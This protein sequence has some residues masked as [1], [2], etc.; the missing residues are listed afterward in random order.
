MASPPVQPG[1]RRNLT[2]NSPDPEKN[3]CDGNDFKQRLSDEYKIL[4]DKIDKI[5]GFRFTVKGWSITAV[6]A[7]SVAA[8]GKSLSTVCIITLGLALM[9][10]FFFWLEY[11]QV[12]WSRLFGN[13]A[14]RIEDTFRKISHG[15]G[16][17]IHGA[18]PVP[19][20]AHELVL[21]G[22]RMKS[23]ERKPHTRARERL[24]IWADKWRASKQ[25]HIGFYAVL[26]MLAFAMLLPHH[27][28]IGTH[29]T[30]L[31]QWAIHLTHPH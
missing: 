20:T 15:K 10:V 19:Y 8:S 3:S 24:T 25:A 13:R 26:M 2:T 28:A 9:L 30:E 17:E 1:R 29:W 6:I 7:A 5:G 4:Q 23:R 22:Y 12:K 14:G 16:K 18:F 31:K 21:A 11:E 27:R